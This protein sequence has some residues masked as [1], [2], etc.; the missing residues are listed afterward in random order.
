MKLRE[1]LRYLN[2]PITLLIWGLCLILIWRTPLSLKGLWPDVAAYLLWLVAQMGLFGAW[3]PTSGNSG[4]RRIFGVV[5]RACCLV[6][7]I[8]SIPFVGWVCAY[9]RVVP[10]STTEAHR[11]FMPTGAWGCGYGSLTSTRAVPWFPVLEL[12]TDFEPCAADDFGCY[13]R[14]GSWYECYN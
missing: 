3:R 11:Y 5:V 1:R 12:E 14:T 10:D 13:I 8:V 4:S 2:H 9:K 7:V 6:G